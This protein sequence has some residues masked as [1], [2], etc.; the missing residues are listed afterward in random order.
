MK[1]ANDKTISQCVVPKTNILVILHSLGVEGEPG[2]VSAA[3]EDLQPLVEGGVLL[4][5]E[6]DPFLE[7][8]EAALL[9][10]GVVAGGSGQDGPGE[11]VGDALVFQLPDVCTQPGALLLPMLDV[12]IV[13]GDA[14]L[15][16]VDA[17]PGVLLLLDGGQGRW[18]CS[19]GHGCRH[20]G[21]HLGVVDD[22]CRQAFVVQGAGQVWGL[23]VAVVTWGPLHHWL[24]AGHIQ[25][26]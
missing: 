6:D 11:V 20:G 25:Y 5:E 13:A 1:I 10:G 22:T 3:A 14:L 2:L 7:E 9:G 16:G 21:C 19:R 8:A 24:V 17:Q 26:L 4:L 23:A 15:G 12:P 18:V